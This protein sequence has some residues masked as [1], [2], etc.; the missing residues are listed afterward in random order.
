MSSRR[1]RA[2]A[3]IDFCVHR[4]LCRWYFPLLMYTVFGEIIVDP[5]AGSTDDA[6]ISPRNSAPP[7]A[8]NSVHQGY[9]DEWYRAL[10]RDAE[11][12]T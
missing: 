7:D 4:L 6:C 3:R 2:V 5:C 11:I 10:L 8:P 1:V 9:L 12:R